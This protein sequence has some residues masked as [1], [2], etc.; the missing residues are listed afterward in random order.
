MS[1]QP[2]FWTLQDAVFLCRMLEQISP[3]YGAH[4]VLTGG[5]LYKD[6][7]RKDCDILFYC[8]RQWDEIDESGLLEALT[9]VGFEIG[10]KHGWVTKATYC[11]RNVDLF[12]PDANQPSSIAAVSGTY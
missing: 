3:K 7:P 9:Q 5:T 4:V 2:K 12:F 1:E 6:G 8:I 11:G 10:R